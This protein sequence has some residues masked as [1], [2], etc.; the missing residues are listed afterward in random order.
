MVSSPAVFVRMETQDP[1]GWGWLSPLLLHSFL[2]LSQPL[3]WFIRSSF[4]V[5]VRV[6]FKFVIRAMWASQMSLLAF[7]PLLLHEQFEEH[8]H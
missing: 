2:D 4:I 1:A 6:L 5:C 3:Q 8:W 7:L